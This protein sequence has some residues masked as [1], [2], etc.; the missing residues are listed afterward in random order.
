RLTLPGPTWAMNLLDGLARAGVRFPPRLLL[1]RKAFFT[2]QGVLADVCPSCSLEAALVAEA[3][4]ALAHDWPLRWI[5]APG[6][7]DRA[8]LEAVGGTFALHH[9]NFAAL[10]TVLAEAGVER[11][12]AVLADLG[13]ASPQID[14]PTRGFSYRRPGPLDMRMDPARGQTASALIN[15][16][17]E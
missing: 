8:T 11:A 16:M 5:K 10:P 7:S 3:V 12:D 17:G 1:F 6:D 2:L 9:N 14:D 4:A 15:R 13:V